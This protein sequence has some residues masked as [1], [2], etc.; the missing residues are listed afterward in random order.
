M[1]LSPILSTSPHKYNAAQCKW[2]YQ[3]LLPPKY[4]ENK[5]DPYTRTANKTLL[6]SD[7][8][9]GPIEEHKRL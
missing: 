3:K 5:L 2:K 4:Y 7:L 6:G 1:I 9:T 8:D